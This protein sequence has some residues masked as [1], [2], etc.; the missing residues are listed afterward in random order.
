M[1]RCFLPILL[2]SILY[3]PLA[4]K[5]C[6]KCPESS[7][8]VYAIGLDVSSSLKN[9][10]IA[11]GSPALVRESAIHPVTTVVWPCAETAVSNMADMMRNLFMIFDC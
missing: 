8:V 3:A 10:R 7:V 2:K 4:D 6:V 5:T 9:C 11:A 1:L